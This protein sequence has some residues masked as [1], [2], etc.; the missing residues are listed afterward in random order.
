MKEGWQDDEPKP[1]PV[2]P[3]PE[4]HTPTEEELIANDGVIDGYRYMKLADGRIVRSPDNRSLI[5]ILDDERK[6][7]RQQKLQQQQV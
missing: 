4:P 7:E 5:Q 3:T 1:T 2:V 6:K